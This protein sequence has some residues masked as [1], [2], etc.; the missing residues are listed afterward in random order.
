MGFL[1]SFLFWTFPLFGEKRTLPFG[2]WIPFLDETKSPYYELI[3]FFEV[4]R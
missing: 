2:I 3:Y 1:V 4:R